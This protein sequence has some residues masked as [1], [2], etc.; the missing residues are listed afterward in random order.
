MRCFSRIHEQ[1]LAAFEKKAQQKRERKE[2]KRRRDLLSP[3]KDREREVLSRTSS[4]ANGI[5]NLTVITTTMGEENAR[6]EQEIESESTPSSVFGSFNRNL[7]G[8]N[9]ENKDAFERAMLHCH[10]TVSLLAPEELQ[11]RYAVETR[12]WLCLFFSWLGELFVLRCNF[13]ICLSFRR[14][15]QL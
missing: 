2:Q 4:A 15:F 3:N 10:H 7:N 12:G 14:G 11:R 6:K 1:K 9:S 8:L 5:P 13:T